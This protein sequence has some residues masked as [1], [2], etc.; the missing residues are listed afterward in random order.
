[1]KDNP[2]MAASIEA[3]VRAEVLPNLLSS[4]D[5]EEVPEEVDS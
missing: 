4:S 5:E 1:L 2:E 3:R